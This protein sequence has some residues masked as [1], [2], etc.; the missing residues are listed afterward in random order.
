MSVG[1]AVE[2]VD[3]GA[4][5][6]TVVTS[7]E[8]FHKSAE[9]AEA[10]D[11]ADVTVELSKPIALEEGLGFAVREGGKTVAAGTVNRLL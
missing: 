1:G 6:P 3:L 11:T 8:S 2:I 10:G 5:R 9:Q 4:S 7:I